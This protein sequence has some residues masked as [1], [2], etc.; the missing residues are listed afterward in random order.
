MPLH[1]AIDWLVNESSYLQLYGIVVLYFLLLYFGIAPLFLACCNYLEKHKLVQKIIT[2]QVSKEQLLK[3][4]L[5]SLQSILVFGFSALP[6]IYFIREGIIELA[7]DSALNLFIGLVI[8][9]IWNEVHFFI[10][11]RVM[12][13]PFFMKRVHQVHHQ[14]VTPTVY[15]VYSFH[16]LE[17]LLLSTV[18]I[19]I[20]TFVPLAPLAIFIYPL[21]SI[22][23][24]Y[25]GH[26]NYRFGKGI[27]EHWTLFGTH[28]N[29]HHYKRRKNYGFASNLLDKLLNKLDR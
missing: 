20:A 2:K 16:W 6:L 26:C 25:A 24:N 23:L 12:H 10:V 14:S 28:H 4:K 18:P 8:L 13:L 19:S 9:T 22:L 21:T 17:A 7:R 1:T 5:Y 11:H 29:E 15:S 3:E 27:G